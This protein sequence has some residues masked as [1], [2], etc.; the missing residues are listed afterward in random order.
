MLTE[1]AV[2]AA[3]AAGREDPR[4]AR[5]LLAM[6]VLVDARARPLPEDMVFE[7]RIRGDAVGA[8]TF[9]FD[10]SDGDVYTDGS[11]LHPTQPLLRTAG[12]A[13]A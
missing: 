2:A 13:A 5:G 1:D 10:A 3:H 6:P 9:A 4:F 11:G 12:F 7:C 8:D